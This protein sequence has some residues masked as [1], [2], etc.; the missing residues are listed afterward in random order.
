LKI[1]NYTTVTPTHFNSDQTKGVAGRVAVGKADGA[2]NFCMRIFEIAPGG[3]TPKHT[4]P[5]EHEMFIHAGVGEIYGNGKWNPVGAGTVIFMPQS[6]E[7]QIRNTGKE[8][9]ILACL[10]PSIAPEL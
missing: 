7:H 5:W 8:L 10:V 2:N 9:L 3:N 4:H 1:K 6:E